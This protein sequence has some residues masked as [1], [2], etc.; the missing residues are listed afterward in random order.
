MVPFSLHPIVE[1]KGGV[2]FVNG[3]GGELVLNAEGYKEMQIKFGVNGGTDTKKKLEFGRVFVRLMV[4]G[5][6]VDVAKSGECVVFKKNLNRNGNCEWVPWKQWKLRG[7]TNGAPPHP[8]EFHFNN[9]S[10]LPKKPEIPFSDFPPS[11]VAPPSKSKQP[12]SP[13]PFPAFPPSDGAPQS[14]YPIPFPGFPRSSVAPPS[15]SQQSH[16]PIPFPAF[17]SSGGAPIC[18][19]TFCPPSVALQCSPSSSPPQQQSASC[20]ENIAAE[21]LNSPPPLSPPSCLS[22]D[23]C[24]PNE[25]DSPLCFDHHFSPRSPFESF[26]FDFD[27]DFDF[28]GDVNFDFFE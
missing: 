12:H 24:L 20:L 26:D 19:S 1:K 25:I 10:D 4:D 8:W 14:H 5:Q 18:P 27:F 11:N 15:E 2:D 21:R 22:N 9:H 7:M 6:C 28:E 3:G 16:S 17:P 13:I 23:D